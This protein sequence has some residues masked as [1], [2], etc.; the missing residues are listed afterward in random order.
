MAQS[1]D[2]QHHMQDGGKHPKPMDCRASVL[3]YVAYTLYI[4]RWGCL[5]RARR[6]LD[7]GSQSQQTMSPTGKAAF[8]TTIR[9]HVCFCYSATHISFFADA[10]RADEQI[11][12][13]PKRNVSSVCSEASGNKRPR[14]CIELCSTETSSSRAI[15]S[16]KVCTTNTSADIIMATEG[17]LQLCIHL[18]CNSSS[19]DISYH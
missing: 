10:S 5:L 1:A 8:I 3:Y 17:E 2:G 4:C 12:T 19:E 13:K 15:G 7:K 9:K 14:Q 11:T 6:A 18:K 16:M